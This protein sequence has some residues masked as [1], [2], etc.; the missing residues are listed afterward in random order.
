MTTF[1]SFSLQ[2]LFKLNA[3]SQSFTLQC[4]LLSNDVVFLEIILFKGVFFSFLFSRCL[5]LY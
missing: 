1:H 2:I 5:L 4:F 3:F